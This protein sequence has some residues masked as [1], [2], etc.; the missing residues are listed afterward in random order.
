VG[1]AAHV[2]RPGAEARPG[3]RLSA[4]S[5][6]LRVLLPGAAAAVL[7]AVLGTVPALAH[8]SLV[9]SD[10]ADGA[11]LARAPGVVALDFT[12]PAAAELTRVSLT[13]SAGRVHELPA[14]A[15]SGDPRYPGRLLVRLPS[16]LGRDSYR[17]SFTT[18]D[19]VDL[20][21][22]SGTL[23]FGIAVAPPA[24]AQPAPAP[25]DPVEVALRWLAFA[26]LAALLGGLGLAHLVLP[27]ALARGALAAA[28]RTVLGLSLAGVVATAVGETCLLAV[29][30]RAAGGSG[31]APLAR[32]VLD[33]EFGRRWLVS[34]ALS[35]GLAPL[36]WWLR[37]RAAS[38]RAARGPVAA[39]RRDGPLALLAT[40]GRTWL[41]ALGQAAVLGLS[42]HGAGAGTLPDL[43][44]RGLH[45]ASTGGW[46]GGLLGLALLLRRAGPARAAAG[47]VLRA[48]GPLA[49]GCVAVAAVTGLLLSAGVVASVTALLATGYGLTLVAKVALVGAAAL[50]GLRHAWLARRAGVGGG[51]AP[52]TLRVEAGAALSAV[53][54]AAVLGSSAP[55]VGRQFD[56]A[57][58]PAPPLAL[59]A[60]AGD[61]LVRLAIE[62]NR[63]GRNLM[64]VVVVNKRRPV[65]AA[66]TAITVLLERPGQAPEGRAA[67]LADGFARYDAGA[68]D[69][70]PGA[71]AVSVEVDRPPLP[72]TTQRFAWSVRAADPARHPVV[73]SDAPLAPIATGL[74]AA[75]AAGAA[76]AAAAWAWRRRRRGGRAGAAELRGGVMQARPRPDEAMR[77]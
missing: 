8:T 41:L 7:L 50:L 76:A 72:A 10:P 25:P 59:A 39:L 16:S 38:G 55:A 42:S 26:G 6:L 23:V 2:G 45:L 36:L 21:V 48:F 61:L 52:R 11:V 64:A 12:R 40:A 27:R 53:L 73:V 63:P 57:P 56:P 31:A 69:L 35:A 37:R 43:A 68:V 62:P 14:P 49:A 47:P 29:Q 18:Y 17:L 13:D 9:G 46:A 77:G 4:L 60:D 22:T 15:V 44:V 58:P 24:A 1:D 20:H 67:V 70:A 34:A 32:L 30:L 33:G 74:A 71:L 54:L 3:D 66:I 5:R 19:Q 65:P 75:L 51:R 28:Q